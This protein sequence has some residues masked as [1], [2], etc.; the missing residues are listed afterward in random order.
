MKTPSRPAPFLSAPL[1][2]FRVDLD[3]TMPARPYCVTYDGNRLASWHAS[4]TEA[5][6]A[7]YW[8]LWGPQPRDPFAPGGSA[9]DCLPAYYAA[10]G[11]KGD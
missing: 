1:A 6:L 5:V 4:A 8:A 10:P 2:G 11:Y 3:A 9:A 7:G